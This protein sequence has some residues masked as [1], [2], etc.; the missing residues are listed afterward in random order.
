MD[1]VIKSV[2]A[3][4]PKDSRNNHVQYIETIFEDG[5]AKVRSETSYQS[6]EKATAD[7]RPVTNGR[8]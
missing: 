8:D 4:V 7:W 6:A 3:V 2:Q 1:K 5:S